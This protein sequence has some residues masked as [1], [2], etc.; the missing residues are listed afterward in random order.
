MCAEKDVL[1]YEINDIL[2]CAE[3]YRDVT[4]QYRR[5]QACD[6]CGNTPAVRDPNHRRNEYLCW[7]CH[8]ETGFTVNNTVI[9]RA[10]VSMVERY[11]HRGPRV[12]CDA[13]GYGTSCD[14]NVKPRG[15]W[16]GKSLCDTHGKKPPKPNKS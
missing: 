6:F 3:H 12:K 8:E 7:K 4:R 15:A 14:D 11:I 16:G 10:I 13:S 2:Y 5:V 9:K 1:V